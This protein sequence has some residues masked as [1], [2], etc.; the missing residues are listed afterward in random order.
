MYIIGMETACKKGFI[1]MLVDYFREVTKPIEYSNEP[2]VFKPVQN[3]KEF[4]C[5]F[6]IAPRIIFM[7]FMGFREMS[8]PFLWFYMF[9][10]IHDGG[11]AK[12]IRIDIQVIKE[13]FF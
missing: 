8:Q 6:K 7:L 12:L 3:F 4:I 13:Y 1:A 11:L 5:L 9:I 2:P 10:F